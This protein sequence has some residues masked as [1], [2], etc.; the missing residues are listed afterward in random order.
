MDF[1][2]FVITGHF[3]AGNNLYSQLFSGINGIS[4][5]GSCI[6]VGKGDGAKTGFLCQMYKL[7]RSE[8]AV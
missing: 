6:M 8:A 3:N 1:M 7:G 5:P 2:A 4:N